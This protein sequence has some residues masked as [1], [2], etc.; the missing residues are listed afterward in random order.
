V[1]PDCRVDPSEVTDAIHAGTALVTIMHA[2]NETGALQPIR[3]IAQ[4][5]GDALLHTDAAQS[6]GKVPIDVRD[7]QVDL[8]SLAGHKLYAPKGVGALF[9]RRGTA[10]EPLARG[11]GHEQGLRPGTENVPSIVGL[12][13][14]CALALTDLDEAARR[15][16]HLTQRLW[17]TLSQAIP[18]LHP[19]GPSTD[20]LPN[21]LNL[22][23]PGVSG[24]E[25]LSCT[26]QIAA[27]TAGACHDGRETHSAVLAAM[28]IPASIARGAIRLSVG[29]T[30]TADEVD[31]AAAALITS[32][33]TLQAR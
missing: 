25:L 33:R 8:L 17:D 32:W 23:F 19:T 29:R 22:C 26:P 14:A 3:E 9:V 15:Q 7:L 2:N 1:G 13:A 11:A 27:S 21:T 18:D 5:K 20:R 16:D 30:T 6:V 4:A 12:G 28:G 31:A 24:A 10:I